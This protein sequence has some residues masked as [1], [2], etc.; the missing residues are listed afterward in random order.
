LASINTDSAL[1]PKVIVVGT[2][3]QNIITD[4]KNY[5]W[6]GKRNIETFLHFPD[7]E[8]KTESTLIDI[9]SRV[10]SRQ[11]E[12][13]KTPAEE[14]ITPEP[15][16]VEEPVP[17]E[18]VEVSPDELGFGF[19]ET[20]S[21]IEPVQ[22]IIVPIPDPKQSIQIPSIPKINFKLNLKFKLPSFRAFF[23]LPALSPLLIIF[24]VFYYKIDL[25]LAFTP[26]DFNQTI[27]VTLDP[28]V[29]QVSSSN[30]IPVSQ[31][32]FNVKL[33]LST[34]AT[35][36]KTV[37]DKSKG[38]I[39]IF[40]KLDRVQNIPKGTVLVNANGLKFTTTTAVQVAASTINLDMGIITMG[41]T[42]AT[43][44]AADIGPEYNIAKDSKLD[45]KDSSLSIMQAKTEE[46][47]N[48]GTKN[49]V[50]V[51][52]AAD[53]AKLE[54]QIS[55]AVTDE[56]NK[57]I[58]SEV[59]NLNGL[60]SET[61]IIKKNRAEYN[62]EV[63]EEADTLS[64]DS[65]NSITAYT[66]ESSTK[67]TIIADLTG[68]KAEYTNTSFNQDKFTFN[69]APSTADKLKG[70]LTIVG[71]LNPSPDTNL[72][73]HQIVAKTPK[74]LSNYIP[75][76]LSRVYNYQITS[77][78]GFLTKIIMPIRWQNISIITK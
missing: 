29:S 34:P 28:S 72:I 70:K 8:T 32:N 10:I 60:L 44:E 57:K 63:G 36:Q 6:I 4:L 68:Q 20:I 35:G 67:K 17:A 2:Y 65:D 56:V 45:F 71:S 19:D 77:N 24:L 59:S 12:P 30:I 58:N 78:L 50:L 51:V 15:E 49:V 3:E 41:Q 69:F 54:G 43:I 38:Q 33:N 31:K 40:N 53:K 55:S 26:I 1:Q 52:A 27:G 21:N 48:G 16:V 37:G 23:I 7:F 11:F 47:L 5:P 75:K 22:E 66:L 9:Y 61:I 62:R 73:R 14:T 42:K 39:V 25:T 64:V 76:N 13:Q 18:I 74:F 46:N